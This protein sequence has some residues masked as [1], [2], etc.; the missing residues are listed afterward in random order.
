MLGAILDAF[1][2]GLPELAVL[3]LLAAGTGFVVA[4]RTSGDSASSS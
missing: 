4:S 3:T 2:M 1:G